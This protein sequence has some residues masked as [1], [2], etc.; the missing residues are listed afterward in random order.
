VY[1]E[2]EELVPL[3]QQDQDDSDPD[4][5]EADLDLVNDLPPP[6]R[7]RF[8]FSKGCATLESVSFVFYLSRYV[9]LPTPISSLYHCYLLQIVVAARF[10]RSTTTKAHR[11]LEVMKHHH[12]F[13]GNDYD[14]R[15]MEQFAKEADE[16]SNRRAGRI[17]AL[18]CIS[19]D[20]YKEAIEAMEDG[21]LFCYVY[22]RGS[23]YL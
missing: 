16:S 15:K 8:H 7:K 1:G 4:W 17:I 20:L 22:F 14:L 5:N 11:S 10:Y 3:D 2:E 18:Q 6:D 12:R 13:I 23:F 19:D 21:T 9:V